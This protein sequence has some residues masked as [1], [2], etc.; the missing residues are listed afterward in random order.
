MSHRVFSTHVCAWDGS[1][2]PS[3]AATTTAIARRN[4]T[5][6][7]SELR[8]R[9]E[10]RAAHEVRVHPARRLA[11]L[12]DRP[13]HQRLPAACVAAGEHTRY[14]RLVIRPGLHVAALRQLAAEL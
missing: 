2:Q 13:H 11:A 8:A 6:L 5:S 4:P 12:P 7:R 3:T 9:R 1:A 14:R 10:P